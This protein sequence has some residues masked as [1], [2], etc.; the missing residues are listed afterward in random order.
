LLRQTNGRD[1]HAA[2]AA[3]IPNEVTAVAETFGPRFFQLFF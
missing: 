2:P 1:P 3:H